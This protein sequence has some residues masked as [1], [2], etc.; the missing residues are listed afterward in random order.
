MDIDDIIQTGYVNTT[1]CNISDNEN[2]HFFVLK[3][4]WID[5]TSRWIH[6]RIDQRVADVGFG[7]NL[8]G[9]KNKRK[10][11]ASF[12]PHV[13]WKHSH[14]ISIQRDVGCP[15][16]PLSGHHSVWRIST[17]KS[18]PSIVRLDDNVQ[19]SASILREVLIQRLNESKPDHRDQLV[20]SQLAISA[21][22]PRTWPF[23]WSQADDSMFRSTVHQSPF[24]TVDQPRR[25]RRILQ[26]EAIRFVTRCLGN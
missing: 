15:R 21:A 6:C 8:R 20:R 13:T 24:R 26:T 7:Q 3:F 1:S 2:R 23:V 22:W 19:I 18:M 16:K 11:L 10:S 14:K 4:R 12:A 5:F 25:K 17:A 9:N